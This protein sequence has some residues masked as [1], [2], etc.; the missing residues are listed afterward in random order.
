M[1]T[2]E[3]LVPY[4]TSRTFADPT[5][6][7]AMRNVR[8]SFESQPV[9]RQSQPDLATRI[10]ALSDEL[11]GLKQRRRSGEITRGEYTEQR[12]PLVVDYHALLQAHLAGIGG[13]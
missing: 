6:W 2:R 7:E 13:K 12:T 11:K 10:R 9:G 4:V 1:A 3:H 5:A 8:R